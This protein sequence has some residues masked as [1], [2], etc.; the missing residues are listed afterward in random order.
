MVVDYKNGIGWLLLVNQ[1][2]L[3]LLL[4]T[5]LTLKLTCVLSNNL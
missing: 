3:S 5:D 2:L 1:I 4:G